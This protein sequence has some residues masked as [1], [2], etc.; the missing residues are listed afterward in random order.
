MMQMMYAM[1]ERT[2]KG[3]DYMND[4][5]ERLYHDLL[6]A[7]VVPLPTQD[8][9]EPRRSDITNHDNVSHKKPSSSSLHEKM[10][11][12]D[13]LLFPNGNHPS[14]KG[15]GIHIESNVNA[16]DCMELTCTGMQMQM[17]IHEI[18]QQIIFKKGR[19]RTQ[20]NDGDEFKEIIDKIMMTKFKGEP[21]TNEDFQ[22]WANKMDLY[23]TLNPH[24]ERAK[25]YFPHYTLKDTLIHGDDIL[26]PTTAKLQHGILKNSYSESL[27]FIF[28]FGWEVPKCVSKSVHI[29]KFLENHVQ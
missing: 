27:I 12:K 5:F 4:G 29:H 9:D 28:T 14:I 19:K 23:F 17:S 2:T 25:M 16:R 3:Y 22:E 6:Q 13:D 7:M 10:G 20:N 21:N 11:N 26:V 24:T 18:A 8:H 1:L 15:K